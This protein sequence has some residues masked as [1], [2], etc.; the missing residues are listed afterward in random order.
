MPPAF[1]GR[2]HINRQRRRTEWQANCWDGG[3]PARLGPEGLL[4]ARGNVG[5]VLRELPVAERSSVAVDGAGEDLDVVGAG[6]ALRGEV[7]E[8]TRELELAWRNCG[9]GIGNVDDAGEGV[10][11]T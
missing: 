11:V 6:P 2:V 8:P 4:E 10:A 7:D 3:A 5:T 9:A 1:A